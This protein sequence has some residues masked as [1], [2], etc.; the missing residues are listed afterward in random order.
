META[1][2]VF[3]VRVLVTVLHLLLCWPCCILSP[4]SHFTLLF[5]PLWLVGQL[6]SP[7]PLRGSYSPYVA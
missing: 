3:W 4:V 2:P 6:G 7:L 1:V 5:F